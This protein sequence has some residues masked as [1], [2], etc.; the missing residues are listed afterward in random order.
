MGSGPSDGDIRNLSDLVLNLRLA[1]AQAAA[2]ALEERHPEHPAGPFFQGIA[3]YQRLLFEEPRRP[4]TV[5]E[6]EAHNARA[7]TSAK[8]MLATA[9]AWGHYYLAAAH[10]FQAR[11]LALGG[12]LR[13]AIPHVRDSVAHVRKSVESG[14]GLEDVYLGLGMY[15]Y[16]LSRVPPTLKP[17]AYLVTGLWGNRSLGLSHI[18][19]AAEKGTAARWEARWVLAAILLLDWERGWAEGGALLAELEAR[20]PRNPA[21]RLGRGYAAEKQGAW[22]EAIALYDPKA[23]GTAAWDPLVRDRALAACRYRRAES[24]LLSGRPKEAREYL[25]DLDKGPLPASLKDWVILRKANALDAE[26]RREEARELYRPISKP[27]AQRAA[28]KFLAEPY[29]KGSRDI[30]PFQWPIT[31]VAR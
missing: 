17:F 18:R 9:P 27:R 11:V 16:L 15:Y 19:R 24:Y 31:D 23:P 28:K 26:G 22:S 14:P 21:F 8:A 4:Q 3:V 5:R 1:E 20:Y 13:E 6:F 2:R 25:A 12:R 30:A 7:V 10:G 29:P